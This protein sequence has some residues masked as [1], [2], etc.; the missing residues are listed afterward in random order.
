MIDRIPRQDIVIIIDRID[1][2]IRVFLP[3][4]LLYFVMLLVFAEDGVPCVGICRYE[5]RIGPG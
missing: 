4:C 1:V 2:P 5:H 3:G